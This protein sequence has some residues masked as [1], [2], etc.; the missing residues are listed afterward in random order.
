VEELVVL[1]L[2]VVDLLPEEVMEKVQVKVV[3]PE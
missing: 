2:V 3:N 1:V